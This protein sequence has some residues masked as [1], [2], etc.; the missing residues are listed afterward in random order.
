[1]DEY[2]QHLE[3]PTSRV[4][5]SSLQHDPNGDMFVTNTDEENIMVVHEKV[6][7]IDDA[8]S[9]NEK[10]TEHNKCYV[11]LLAALRLL[12]D[13]AVKA[14][15]DEFLEHVNVNSTQIAGPAN[16]G[17]LAFIDALVLPLHYDI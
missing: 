15:A 2:A 13:S 17:T 9:A 5:S 1:M 11:E 4:S 3:R 10:S 12:P 16:N 14:L 8:V 6:T 7:C